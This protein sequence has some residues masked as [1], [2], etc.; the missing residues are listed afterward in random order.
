MHPYVACFQTVLT[1][2]G[3]RRDR[4]DRG[5]VFA[6]NPFDRLLFEFN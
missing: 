6:I 4:D 3:T 1:A 2:V 5:D